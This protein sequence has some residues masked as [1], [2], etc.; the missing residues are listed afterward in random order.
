MSADWC[1]GGA[2]W[3]YG[4]VLKRDAPFLYCCDEHGLAYDEGGGWRDRALADNRSAT[5]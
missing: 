3:L 5:A 4:H 2:S 1:S